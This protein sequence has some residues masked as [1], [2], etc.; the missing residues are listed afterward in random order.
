MKMMLFEMEI[1][2][3]NCGTYKIKIKDDK[4]RTEILFSPDDKKLIFLRNDELTE[5]LKQNEY[6][7]RKILHNKRRDTYYEGFTV[8]FALRSKK[9]V[10]AF[11][12][13]SKIVILD[14]RKGK[15]DSYVVNQGEKNIYKI[16]TDGSFLERKGKGAYVAIIKDLNGE[17]SFYSGKTNEKSSS[18]IELL[19]A[20]KG[21]EVLKNI[22]KIR[23]VTDSQYVRKGLTEWIV[24]W[25]LNDWHTANGEKVKHIEYWKK[26]DRLTDNKYIEFEWVKAHSNHFENTLCDLYAKEIA[27]K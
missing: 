3:E 19:A 2:E 18:L 24:N 21:L 5:I 9:D 17:Y 23:I 1:I 25:K 10:A 27:G 22:E 26:F 13:R 4:L 15:Y 11:N 12:D 16:Y 8:K 20:I 14:K 6:Q 7:L